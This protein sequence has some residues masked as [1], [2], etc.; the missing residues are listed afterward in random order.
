MTSQIETLGDHPR[1]EEE[2]HHAPQD[3]PWEVGV[4]AEAVEAEE[5][6]E[7][8]FHCPDRHPPSKLKNF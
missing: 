1:E 6:E 2:D 3:H 5:G 4:E 8:H 7:E